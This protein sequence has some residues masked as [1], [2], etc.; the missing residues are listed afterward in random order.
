MI[1]DSDSEQEGQENVGSGEACG[2]VAV[3]ESEQGAEPGVGSG[4]FQHSLS[5]GGGKVPAP[6]ALVEGGE[7]HFAAVHEAEQTQAVRM[8]SLL[9][10]AAHGSQNRRIGIGSVRIEIACD[11]AGLLEDV[12]YDD[13]FPDD[14]GT[15]QQHSQAELPV[16]PDAESGIPPSAGAQEVGAS[17]PGYGAQQAVV[18][19]IDDEV[20]VAAAK[21]SVATV[22]SMEVHIAPHELSLRVSAEGVDEYFAG[23]GT[24]SIVGVKEIYVLG[25]HEPL[26]AFA[27]S[28]CSAA[29]FAC[30]GDMEVRGFVS[31]LPGRE[32][33]RSLIG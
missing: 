8:G 16:V 30:D 25:L 31:L 19:M 33:V 29:G 17:A 12:G 27:G 22:G 23:V 28:R 20:A 26:S 14:P 1:S 2:A 6:F 11:G 24:E 4:V 21:D 18:E 9:Q 5:K 32:D 7:H 15:L 3:A 10:T 13:V